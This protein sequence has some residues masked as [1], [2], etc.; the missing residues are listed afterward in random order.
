VDLIEFWGED[1]EGAVELGWETASENGT[2]GFRLMR[3]AD[4][5]GEYQLITPK[6][7]DAGQKDYRYTDVRVEAGRTYFYKLLSVSNAGI[8]KEYDPVEVSVSTPR[9]FKLHPNYPNPFNPE[10]TIKYEIP[11]QEKVRILIYN[12]LGQVVKELVNDNKKSGYY[13]IKWHGTD[14]LGRQAASGIYFYRINAGKFNL[15]RKMVLIR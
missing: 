6:L 11:R 4:K 15:T 2:A 12:V 3:T 9:T 13:T 5:N 7:I 10:T 1:K 14:N 8:P